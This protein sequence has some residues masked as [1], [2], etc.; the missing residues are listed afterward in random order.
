M[1]KIYVQ[2]PNDYSFG[3]FLDFAKEHSC[4]LEIASFAYSE[5]LDTEWQEILKRYQQKLYGFKGRVS[6]HGAF[7]D[8]FVHSSDRKIREVS[9]ERILGNLEIAKALNAKYAVFHG[10][11]NPL[12]RGEGYRRNWV[13]RNASFWSKALEESYV[14]V[15]LE[16]L[17]EPNPE[18]FRKLL[19]QIESSRLKICFDTGHANIFSEVSFEEWITILGKDIPYIHINDNKGKVDN[20]LVP[21][22]GTINWQEF[23][24]TIEE[25]QVNPEIVFEV[26]TLGKTKRSIRYFR[27]ESIYPFSVASQNP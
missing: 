3:E 2:P 1:S 11:F 20:E 17:W 8:L 22:E 4:N 7:Q 14:T 27:K 18:M 23:S 12:I 5:V 24:N 19:D 10:N 26:G 21:G 6:V 13:E 9:K 15:L 16:N 25:H